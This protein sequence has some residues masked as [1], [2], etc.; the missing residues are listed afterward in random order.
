MKFN[1][2]LVGILAGAA[3]VNGMTAEMKEMKV[4]MEKEALEKGI[5][6]IKRDS[7]LGKA[8]VCS[9]EGFVTLNGEEFPCH[10]VDF[11]SF[12]AL[13]DM[14]IDNPQGHKPNG[15][16][17]SDIWGWLS[18]S[19]REFTLM[20]QD[21]G[22]SFFDTTDPTNPC[23]VAQLP[24]ARRPQTWTDIKV[25]KDTAY[26]VK[27]A[28]G[29]INNGDFANE[30]HIGG[31]VLDLLRLEEIQCDGSVELPVY[32]ENDFLWS[33][34]G[35]SHNLAINTESG[36]LYSMGCDACS[37][38][39]I[40]IDLNKN[41]LRPEYVTCMD[42]DGYTH[43]LQVVNYYGPDERY[44]G[45]EIMFAFNE[46]TVTIWDVTDKFSPKILSKT[47]YGGQVYTHQGWANEDLTLLFVDDE[48]NELCSGNINA[49]SSCTSF[50]LNGVDGIT[51]TTTVVMDITDL[52]NPVVDGAYY[53]PD[54]SIDHNLY[55]WGA[56]HTHGWGG[57][58]PM[59]YPPDDRFIYLNNYVAGLKILDV[60][61]K[62]VDSF[63]LAG[64][65]DVSPELDDLIF[66][67]AWSGYLHPSGA[68]AI[69]SIDRGL[70]MVAPRMAYARSTQ[71]PLAFPTE[72]PVESP[73]GESPS[74]DSDDDDKTEFYLMIIIGLLLL[75]AG[76][77]IG[78]LGQ[79]KPASVN[80]TSKTSKG[81]PVTTVEAH[82]L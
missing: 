57:N 53:M 1:L 64:Y 29:G 24:S 40:V 59:E 35:S 60:S 49:S 6:G 27:E 69:S 34:H 66:Q 38:G 26:I 52:E 61:S 82:E 70:F 51:N 55:H 77:F 68:Y 21:N 19:G 43:D 76:I 74:D 31:E 80:V 58:P 71:N 9:N 12:V 3:V 5:I 15:Q 39:P 50:P 23:L 8:Q 72:A 56:I 44:H 42:G 14:E 10:E 17:G 30:T 54:R 78:F 46:D 25:Y 45:H 7:I 16:G 13:A 81:G 4:R 22:V 11:L 2:P 47:G 65:F 62:D 79:R 33:F 20:G 18:P 28:R 67:G 36:Y 48:L 32:I 41:R 73:T 75:I 63:E 37:G